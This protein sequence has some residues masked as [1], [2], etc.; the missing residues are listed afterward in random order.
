[1]ACLF[2]GILPIYCGSD[3]ETIDHAHL[4]SS[5]RIPPPTDVRMNPT[6]TEIPVL[7]GFAD[8]SSLSNSVTRTLYTLAAGDSFLSLLRAEYNRALVEF[9][10]EAR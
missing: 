8:S 5:P 7:P 1:V 10:R 2:G 3:F 9:L 4:P 6:A